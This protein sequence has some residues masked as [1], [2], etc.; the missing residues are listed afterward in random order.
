MSNYSNQNTDSANGEAAAGTKELSKGSD[1]DVSAKIEDGGASGK[2]SKEP[3]LK[4]GAR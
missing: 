4:S 3:S 1:V 2:G